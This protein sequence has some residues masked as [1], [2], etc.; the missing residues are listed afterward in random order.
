MSLE[1]TNLVWAG[2]PHRAEHEPG[3]LGFESQAVAEISADNQSQDEK[4]RIANASGDYANLPFDR[5]HVNF[6]AACIADVTPSTSGALAAATNWAEQ[7]EAAESAEDGFTVVKHKRRRRESPSR[8]VEQR[9]SGVAASRRTGPTPRRRPPAGGATGVQMIRATQADIADAR[10]RQRSSTEDNCVFVEHCPDFGSTHY[11]QAVEEL[12]GGAGNVLQVMKMDGHML[13][14][15]STKALAERLIRDGLDIGHT[16][17]RAF[18]FKKRA[19]R[20]TVGNLPFFVDD[21]AVIEALKPYSDVT[22]IVPIR[23]R[24]GRYTFT[25]GRREAFILLKE[26]IALEKI[27]TRVII[28]NKGNV[29]S[30]FISYGVKCSRC[31]RQG[32]RRAN[33]PIIPGRA[34]NNV[35][36]QPAPLPS[37]ASSTESRQPN[38]PTPTAP[39]PSPKRP[40]SQTSAPGTPTALPARTSSD[41]VAPPSEP[42]EIAAEVLAP[43]TSNS[44]PQAV[45][46]MEAPEAPA[47]LRPPASQPAGVAPQ[48]LPASAAPPG[49]LHAQGTLVPPS[50]S[51]SEGK[52]RPD[53]EAYLKRNPGV[54][55]A[56]TDALGLGREEVLDILSSK[57]KAHKRGQHLTPPQSNALAGLINQILD[58]RPGGNSNIYKVLRQVLSELRTGQAAVPPT[59]TLPAPR[60]FHPT[61]L[62]SHKKKLTPAMITP[63]APAPTQMGEVVPMTEVERCVPPL[64]APQPAEPAPPAPQE[65]TPATTTPPLPPPAPM[66]DDVDLM[67]ELDTI[68]NEMIT[69]PGFEPLLEP[70]ISLDAVMFAVLY[71]E[72][73]LD[74]LGDLSPEQGRG[75]SRDA[76][77]RAAIQRPAPSPRSASRE[78]RRMVPT[79]TADPRAQCTDNAIQRGPTPHNVRSVPQ[80]TSTPRYRECTSSAVQ[81][82]VLRRE[83]LAQRMPTSTSPGDP[84]KSADGAK[85]SQNHQSRVHSDQV[86]PETPQPSRLFE[87]EVGSLTQLTVKL[88]LAPNIPCPF[89]IDTGASLNIVPYNL[90]HM[91]KTHLPNLTLEGH[92]LDLQTLNGFAKTMGKLS[93]PLTIGQISRR[94]NFH[95]VN[96]P[97]PFGILSINSLH[98]FRL[99][100]DFNKCTIFQLG[101]PLS[102]PS[103]HFNNV[104]NVCTY[105]QCQAMSQ[106]SYHTAKSSA[107]DNHCVHS[108]KNTPLPT[109]PFFTKANCLFYMPSNNKATKALTCKKPAQNM[110]IQQ[111]NSHTKHIG[112]HTSSHNYMTKP[113]NKHDIPNNNTQTAPI[114]QDGFHT[115]KHAPIRHHATNT[116]NPPNKRDTRAKRRQQPVS[117]C[118]TVKNN[119][120]TPSTQNIEKIH[121]TKQ[122][123]NRK[124]LR[125]FLKAVNAYKEFIPDHARLR[126]PLVNLLKRDVMWVWGDECQKAFTNLKE[127]LTTHPT[128]HLYQEGLPC[129]VYCNTSTFGIAGILKQVY[130][131]GKTYPVQH[132]SRSLRGHERNYSDLELQCLAIVESVD[133]F[134][135]CLMG[136]KFTILSDHPALQWLKEIKAPSGRLFRWR[137]RL[138]RY[139]YEVRS[140]NGVQQYETGVVTRIPFC[141]FL[142]A[143]LIKSQQSS[144]PGKSRVTMDH[145]EVRT[146]SRKGVL[147]TIVPSSLTARL[148]KSVHTQHHHPNISKMTRLIS[149]QYYWQNMTQDIAKQSTGCILTLYEKNSNRFPSHILQLRYLGKDIDKR[150]AIMEVETLIK[151][152]K[153]IKKSIKGIEENIESIVSMVDVNAT[154]CKLEYAN[155]DLMKMSDIF[156][157][158]LEDEDLNDEVENCIDKCI[159]LKCELDLRHNGQETSEKKVNLHVKMPKL[160]LPTF[161]GGLESWLSFKDLFYSAI[162]SNSQIP[163]IEKLQ[164]LK[165]QLR[166]EALKLVNA[167][168]I[169][170]DNY[171]EV[172][173]TLLTRYDNPKDL[174]FT[175]I[176]NAL[177]LPKLADDNHKSMFKLIDSCNEIV[178]TVKVLGYQIDSLSDVFFVEIIQDKLDKTTRKQWELQNNPRVVPSIKDLMEFLEI[179][180]KSLQNLPNKDANVE[181]HSIRRE[182]HKEMEESSIKRETAPRMEVQQKQWGHPGRS[183][184]DYSSKRRPCRICL[185]RGHAGRFHPENRLPLNNLLKKDVKWKWDEECETA[186]SKLKNMITSKPIL[187]IYNPK[188]PIHLYTDASQ[189]QIGSILKQEQPDGLLKPIAYRSRRMTS[190][191]S[192][193]CVT[194]QEC[195]AIIDAVDFFLPYLD[196][197]HF[198]IHTD[199]ACLKYLKNIKNPKGRL[200]RWSL[201]L[202]MFD[203]EIKHIRGTENKEADFLSRY[204]IAHFVSD[205][206]LKQAQFDDNI[207]DRKYTKFNGLLTI[208]KKGLIKSVVPPSLR[209]KVLI[210]AH[211]NYGHIGVSKMLN[212]ISPIYYWPYLIQDISNYVK[213]CEVCQLNKI[214]HQK[215][216]GLLE[217]LPPAKDPFDLVSIDTVGGLNYYNSTKKFLHIIVDHATRYIWAF[218]S[219]SQTTDSY[220]NCLN[221]IFQIQKPKQFLSDRAPSFTSPRFRKYLINNNIKQLLTSSSRPQCNG[222]NERLNQT[223]ITRLRCKFNNLKGK[224]IPW[225]KLLDSVLNEYNNT[226]H[227]ITGYT[228][229][230]LLYGKLP[231]DPPLKESEFYPPIDTARTNAYNNTLKFHQINKIRYDQHYQPSTFKVGDK[232]WLQTFYHPDNRKLMPPMSGPFTI[233]KQISPV[234]YE[235]DKPQSNLGKTTMVIHSS[236]LRPYYSKEGFELKLTKSKIPTLE[237]KTNQQVAPK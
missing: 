51:S 221:K 162:G 37:G 196:G 223:I 38:R 193:Y 200:F 58:L 42:M 49:P 230:Y 7:M 48:A 214:S 10:A 89:L 98:K 225:T 30:A 12:V 11:L 234:N 82:Q 41:A 203:F 123:H 205:P 228:P 22:S 107:Y 235:I 128:L 186:F 113:H 93:I 145:N 211:Q 204:P 40:A 150:I 54:S 149:S 165:G 111:D 153:R 202:S 69:D 109:C 34:S 156:L 112:D 6:A 130:P 88:F 231:Y 8:P 80:P 232:V 114:Q 237:K 226:P 224:S 27:P 62:T 59:S 18:P 5:Q 64:P 117:A 60:P 87:T 91:L 135:A 171:V 133:N 122:P 137:L 206:E 31:G 195:L 115:N 125:S 136:R 180:A 168:P 208:K 72:D 97:L 102:T 148:L 222:L 185:N 161:D 176:D 4:S 14:G 96:A 16:H 124:T 233:L 144:P 167:F 24:A 236:K 53:L 21:A 218:P 212:L 127:S 19:E 43:P 169:T 33:C 164:Y 105:W 44:A 71:R 68:F 173:Q 183:P 1:A 216:F 86:K 163:E 39:V 189:E 174:I 20:I 187:A 219:K 46:P 179:R 143:P 25:D 151:K 119:T 15:L 118:T 227:S 32:H 108:L 79:G 66:E 215:K 63:P 83:T 134:R 47:D 78:P 198:T 157:Q 120:I 2:S 95:V 81:L 158:K 23:L 191:E 159:R 65:S 132:F 178:R 17:L 160:E 99:T 70:G 110:S 84:R 188:Y 61:P 3:R 175:Q 101:A 201:K 140:I 13:V 138:S 207:N 121:A 181:K 35:Q 55:L 36:P 116:H 170:A 52:T 92:S 73:R 141:G 194:E 209:E 220:I 155:N 154:K 106:R 190:Y 26:G 67:P 85:Q 29:L 28:R 76:D 129:Q 45:K 213:H 57:T 74:L 197:V 104:P 142:D 199:H 94:E 126:T 172:W 177:R 229:T 56:E 75:D 103:Y 77:R 210:R 90:Y 217:S 9:S 192:N 100:I 152:L 139:E 182:S 184:M 50:P 166:G 147:K 146:V 131:D